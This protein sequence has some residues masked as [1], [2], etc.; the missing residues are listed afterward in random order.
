MFAHS[1]NFLISKYEIYIPYQNKGAYK[2]SGIIPREN[3]RTEDQN[4]KQKGQA[5]RLVIK[6]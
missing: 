2:T 1:S 4:D 5:S 3:K 6:F